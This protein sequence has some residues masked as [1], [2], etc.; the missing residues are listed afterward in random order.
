MEQ[1]PT[2]AA[3]ALLLTAA[4][5]AGCGGLRDAV[6]LG[7]TSPDALRVIKQDPIAVPPSLELRPPPA[8]AVA[9]DPAVPSADGRDILAGGGGEAAASAPGA[10]S[11]GEAAV[12]EAARVDETDPA[13]RKRIDAPPPGAEED[14]GLLDF[15]KF[16]ES[17][18]GG[19][20]PEGPA[21]DRDGIDAIEAPPGAGG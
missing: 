13:I 1:R 2:A 15:L 10:A 14:D 16:W 12:L 21:G 8:G 20:A 17:D 3:L 11:P 7:K 6:G 19:E 4:A 5:A 18:G 9:E